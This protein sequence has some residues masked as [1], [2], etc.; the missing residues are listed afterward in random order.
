MNFFKK[1]AKNYFIRVN[2]LGCT[3][4]YKEIKKDKLEIWEEDALK[5][6]TSYFGEKIDKIR[7]TGKLI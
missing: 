4:F 1:P 6:F 3:R 7:E 5:F 2:T